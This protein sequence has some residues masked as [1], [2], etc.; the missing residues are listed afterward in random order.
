MFSKLTD[1]LSA[2]QQKI[3]HNYINSKISSSPWAILYFFFKSEKLKCVI[4]RGCASRAHT[5]WH[6]NERCIWNEGISHVLSGAD[7]WCVISAWSSALCSQRTAIRKNE[8]AGVEKLRGGDDD[9][10]DPEESARAPDA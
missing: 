6:M 1:V 3:L 4:F 2:S 5:F 8:W 10:D 9:G 7:S